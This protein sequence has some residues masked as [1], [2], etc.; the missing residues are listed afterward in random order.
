MAI[1][2]STEQ[3]CIMRTRRGRRHEKKAWELLSVFTLPQNTGQ[4]SGTL[5]VMVLA[6]DARMQMSV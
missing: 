3:L 4:K 2:A 1:Y 5:Q 6:H